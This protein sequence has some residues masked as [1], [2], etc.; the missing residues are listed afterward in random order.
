MPSRRVWQL[1]ELQVEVRDV[2]HPTRVCPARPCPSLARLD[3]P[4][5]PEK[6]GLVTGQIR[7]VVVVGFRQHSS[8]YRR[9][10]ETKE[11]VGTPLEG[12]TDWVNSVA[13]SPDGR[14]IVSGSD[15]K[16]IRIW[17]A[18]TGEAVGTPLEG[19]TGSV[20]SV[21]FSPD[22]RQIVSGSGDK[23]IRI[24]NAA[25]G[26][27][28]GTPLEGHT[29]WVNSVAFSPDG[30]H[31]VSGSGDKTIRIWNAATGEAVGTPLEGHTDWVSSVAFSPDG[32]QIVSGSD[33]KTIRIWN[34][35]IGEAA[36]SASVS[37]GKNPQHS[38]TAGS[39][40]PHLT[41]CSGFLYGSMTISAFHGTYLL[42]L[43]EV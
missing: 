24:W 8:R 17:N 28:V 9:G 32:R 23:T 33:D 5:V 7:F 38:Q 27:A 42:S 21:A 4:G 43:Q 14:H 16:T 35:A 36:E 19:H 20:R 13:F 10:V 2:G 25:T 34:A 22:G 15:D 37:I 41:A 6:H 1:I 11:L 29:D 40:A 30:R 31:I 12:H 18:A 3:S 26:E 39:V